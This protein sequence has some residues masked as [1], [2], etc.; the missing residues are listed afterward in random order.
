MGQSHSNS[1]GCPAMENKPASYRTKFP[2]GVDCGPII[3][4]DFYGTHN[5]HMHV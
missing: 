4:E 2:N 3:T 5:Q 1:D